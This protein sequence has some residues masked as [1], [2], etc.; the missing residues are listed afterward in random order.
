VLTQKLQRSAHKVRKIR[1]LWH[2]LLFNYTQ[3]LKWVDAKRSY[4]PFIIL[5]RSRVGSNLLRSYLNT[6]SQ[7][8]VFG[9]V[10][11]HPGKI[12]W[13][14]SGYPQTKSM[15]QLMKADPARFVETQIYGC[16]PKH[17]AAVGFK[18][19]YYHAQDA[20]AESVWNYLRTHTEIKVV[21]LKRRNILR[22]HLSRENAK[23]SHVWTSKSL[24]TATGAREPLHLNY[25]DCLQE[26]TTTR[27]W[28]EHFDAFFASHQKLDL[29]YET[30]AEQAGAELRRVQEFLGVK[31]ENLCAETRK[32][33]SRRLVDAIENYHE[34]KAQFAGTPW[35]SFFED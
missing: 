1:D 16:F 35:I 15:L 30:L 20:A 9:E 2:G 17:I 27:Q 10:F 18:L 26:F 13:D 6:H 29:Y 14:F 24:P 5:C 19:F 31:Y 3:S 28:E 33:S 4:S 12:G 23:M 34:L 7:I 21:H 8:V 11:R 25:T 22:T 32:Q